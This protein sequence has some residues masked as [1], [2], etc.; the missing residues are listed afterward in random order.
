[1]IAT[2]A[3]RKPLELALR[4]DASVGAPG[5]HAF[6]VRE[7]HR[8]SSAH[9]RPP[10]PTYVTFAIRPSQGKRDERVY[11][12]FPNFCKSK[13]FDGKGLPDQI[14]S[15]RLRPPICPSGG[16]ILI[17]IIAPLPHHSL[18][19]AAPFDHVPVHETV[20]EADENVWKQSRTILMADS[21]TMCPVYSPLTP[22]IISTGVKTMKRSAL[23]FVT[24]L[25]TPALIATA[26][27]GDQTGS[28]TGTSRS[29]GNTLMAGHTAAP[30]PA[31]PARCSRSH[32]IP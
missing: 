31:I 30:H 6:A 13:Y 20:H 28:R 29:P 22:Q 32:R 16:P 3:S 15:S 11:T 19:S 21:F 14:G 9:P 27:A 8:S 2:V 26:H 17:C 1:M 5:P 18:T 25:T 12:P 23:L 4:L 10:H 24:L 7:P